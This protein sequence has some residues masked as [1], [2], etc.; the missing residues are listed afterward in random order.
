M[1]SHARALPLITQVRTNGNVT[2]RLG[3]I[4]EYTNG[5]WIKT[6]FR[7]IINANALVTVNYGGNCSRH[8]LL[9]NLETNIE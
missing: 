4:K 7:I 2:I 5:I 6:I 8:K 3:A 1:R 9:M